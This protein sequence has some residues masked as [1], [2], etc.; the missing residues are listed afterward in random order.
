MA[1]LQQQVS[2]KVYSAKC[3]QQGVLNKVSQQGVLNKG[4]ATSY[5]RQN[6]RPLHNG[7][8]VMYWQ[9]SDGGKI[10]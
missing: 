2:D 10:E 1:R 9:M 3:F 7:L 5:S 6:D 8:L 4:F